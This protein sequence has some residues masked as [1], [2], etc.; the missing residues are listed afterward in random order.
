LVAVLPQQ[1]RR[2]VQLHQ[3]QVDHNTADLVQGT[4]QRIMKVAAVAAADSSVAA[5]DIAMVRNQMAA[6]VAAQVS[7]LVIV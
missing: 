1:R 4:Q 6:A 2:S 7:Y 5:A 3:Q